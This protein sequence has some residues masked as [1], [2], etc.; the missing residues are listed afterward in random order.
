LLGRLFEITLRAHIADHALTIEAF[1]QAAQ[2]TLHGF[3]FA[4]LDI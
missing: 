3:S 2:G 1:L 4:D